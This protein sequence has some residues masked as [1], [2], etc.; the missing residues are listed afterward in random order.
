M[1][2]NEGSRVQYKARNGYCVGSGR[3]DVTHG[4]SKRRAQ[5]K[6]KYNRNAMGTSGWHGHGWGRKREREEERGR[7]GVPRSPAL[8][9]L[10]VVVFQP[11]RC[12]L[13]RALS[14][15]RAESALQA[16]AGL[17]LPSSSSLFPPP[18]TC[19]RF[20]SLFSTS[21][22]IWLWYRAAATLLPDSNG[23]KSEISTR[24]PIRRDLLEF[25]IFVR[26]Q[27]IYLCLCI[28][29]KLQLD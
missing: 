6:E 20:H 15:E 26:Q 4:S 13:I 3:S 10:A 14:H 28:R 22:I 18:S 29:W 2:G 5:G 25:Q 23:L 11:L 12:N 27:L 7:N 19:T 1:R 24:S 9:Q 16:G 8:L 21:Y 17:L